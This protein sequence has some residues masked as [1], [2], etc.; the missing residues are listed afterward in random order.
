MRIKSTIAAALGIAF[1]LAAIPFGRGEVDWTAE[2]KLSYLLSNLPPSVASINKENPK[3]AQEIS[4]SYN[5]IRLACPALKKGYIENPWNITHWFNNNVTRKEWIAAPYEF[6]RA[7]FRVIAVQVNSEEKIE[8][9]GQL[10]YALADHPLYRKWVDEGKERFN[11]AFYED[12]H[13]QAEVADWDDV[14][15]DE[16]RLKKYLADVGQLALDSFLQNENIKAAPVVISRDKNSDWL[17]LHNNDNSAIYYNFS[18]GKNTIRDA[19]MATRIALH[20]NFHSIQHF[21]SLWAQENKFQDSVAFRDIGEK[22]T[23]GRDR[24]LAFID[25]VKYLERYKI[26][27]LERDPFYVMDAALPADKMVLYSRDP[28]WLKQNPM[29]GSALDDPQSGVYPKACLN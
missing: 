8:A 16:D 13:L 23:Y 26:S 25:N 2:Q 22:V 17:G 14:V 3:F 24:R 9:L 4:S 27:L 28:E 18:E 5:F 15:K 7:A 20:E 21:I 6:R 1:S 11:K 12:A 29:S 10:N 19:G